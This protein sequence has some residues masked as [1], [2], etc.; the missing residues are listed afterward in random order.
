MVMP[1]KSPL[2]HRIPRELRSDLGKY[3][4]IF[5][6][7]IASIGLVCGYLVA[8]ESMITA[9]N[10]SFDKYHIEDGNF[11]LSKK[12]NRVQIRK[13][14]EPGLRIYENFYREIPLDNG[15]TLR[16]FKD[17]TQ[18]NLPCLMKGRLPEK[19]WGDRHRPYVRGQQSPSGRRSD[20][21]WFHHIHH[22]GS[23]CPL[24]LQ[25]SVSG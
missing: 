7:L 11:L 18:I 6:L 10:E 20:I 2:S 14:E 23:G 4:V 1:R 8:A 22:H 9:Y 21:R 3:L 24:G 12:A 15:S 16:F 17:R 25:Q 5:I 19:P 13:M